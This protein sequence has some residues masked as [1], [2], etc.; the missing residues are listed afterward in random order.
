[1]SGECLSWSHV[2]QW[3]KESKEGWEEIENHPCPEITSVSSVTV[4]DE[5]I[6]KNGDLIWK[7]VVSFFAQS[8]RLRIRK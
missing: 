7:T 5:N 1:M 6:L 3:F 2:F 8:V 4:T